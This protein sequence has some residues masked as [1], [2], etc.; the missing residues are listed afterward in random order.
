MIFVDDVTQGLLLQ[1]QVLMI[2]WFT[3]A[4]YSTLRVHTYLPL[5]GSS[6]LR[7]FSCHG[8]ACRA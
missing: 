4:I 3:A 5:S 1:C 7:Y 6:S 2:S 8:D